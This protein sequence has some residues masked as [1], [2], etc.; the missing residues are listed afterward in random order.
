MEITVR[1]YG[2]LRRYSSAA[3]GAKHRPFTM[4]IQRGATVKQILEK[5]G[6]AAEFVSGVA[7]N[8]EHS[9]L[10]APLRE[11]DEVYLFPPAAGG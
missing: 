7:V 10:S 2:A 9:P 5:L 4:T 3:D 1:L 8:G 11:G 6:I